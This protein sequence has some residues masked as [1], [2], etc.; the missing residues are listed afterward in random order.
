MIKLKQVATGML[1]MS[2]ACCV[3]ADEADIRKSLTENL[4][5]TK[6]G[7][8]TKLPYG[9]LYQVVVNDTNVIYTDEKGE[10]G[11]LGNLIELKS[12]TNLTQMEKDNL[13]AA[14]F[15]KL[16]L[17]DAIVRVK[18]NGKRKLALF[19]DPECPY[20]QGLEK[21]LESVSDVTIYTFLLPLNDIHPGAMRKAELIWCA[22]DRAQAWDDMLL[23]QQEPKDSN[24]DCKTPIKDISELAT[25]L[26]INGTPGIVFA[27]GKMLFGNQPHELIEKM[28]DEPVKPL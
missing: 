13:I 23:R 8:I 20:C 9:S 2:V 25:R 28:L 3:L 19:A 17:D 11:L 5:K 4:P 27:S 16:P 22:K 7:A 21:E 26:S 14:E 18:G 6:I 24:T 15:A 10:M 1:L 12:K